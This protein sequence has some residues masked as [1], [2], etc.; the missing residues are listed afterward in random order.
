MEESVKLYQLTRGSIKD[1]AM[2]DHNAEVKHWLHP[3]ETTTILNDKN[4][5]TSA[6]QIYTDESKTEQGVGAGT[7][8]FRSGIHTKSLKYRLNNRCTNNQAEQLAILKSLQYT[9]SIQT[10]DKTATIHTDSRTTL[11]SL[12][13]NNINSSLIAELRRKV[14]EMEKTDWKIQFCWVKAHAGIQGNELADTLAKEATTNADITE[15]YHKVPKSVV[16]SELDATSVVKWQREWDQT[17][18]GL[19]TKAY[20]LVVAGRLNMKINVTQNFTT[21]VTGHGNVKTYLYHLKI[22]E[23]PTCPCGNK[24]Q[25]IDHLLFEC[26]LL[27]KER[28]N[29]RLG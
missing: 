25:T 14:T 18:K 24:D 15:C 17:T 28:A 26:E 22:I 7:A 27:N 21:M 8:I 23:S 4:K 5:D 19:I 1:D 10:G 13:N 11:D 16:K 9:E 2:I 12:K 6:I 29:P 3:A 20:F